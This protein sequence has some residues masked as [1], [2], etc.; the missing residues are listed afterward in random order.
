MMSTAQANLS[1][2]PPYDVGICLNHAH[3]VKQYRFESGS[4]LL[5]RLREAW[6][7]HL[8]SG[9]AELRTFSH[10]DLGSR[11]GPAR[12]RSGRDVA[13]GFGRRS[14]ERP[15]TETRVGQRRRLPA[16]ILGVD[17]GPRSHD[18]VDAVEDRRLEADV[19]RGQL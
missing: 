6:E 8:L 13:H 17:V 12:C 7:R 4:P 15:A 18:L 11:G 3:G 10:E 2:E 19:R 9:I 14:A 16:G 5:T 1:V